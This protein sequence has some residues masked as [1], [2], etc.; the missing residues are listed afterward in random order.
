M[1]GASKGDLR[2]ALVLTAALSLPHVREGHFTLPVAKAL[3]L[4]IILIYFLSPALAVYW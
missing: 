3:H 4:V 2:A 1:M